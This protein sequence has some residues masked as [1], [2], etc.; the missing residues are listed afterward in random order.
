[1]ILADPAATEA[2]GRDLA[3]ALKIGDV[4][5]LSGDLGAGKTCFARG[6]LEGLGWTGEV[7]SPT[8]PLVIPYDPPLVRLPVWHVDLYRIESAQEAEGLGLDEPLT[9]GTLVI[10][11][12]ERLGTRLWPHALQLHFETLTKGGRRLTA[13][14]PP[15][16]EGRCPFP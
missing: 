5:A 9:D 3:E 12:P 10:E 7:P 15:S 6:L 16:W 13:A 1:M 11:W 4:V 14:V 8:F 2:A